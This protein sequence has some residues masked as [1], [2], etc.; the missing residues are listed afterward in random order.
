MADSEADK[1]QTDYFA[2]RDNIQTCGLDVH[3][4]VFFVSGLGVILLVLF[5]LIFHD[6]AADIFGRLRPWLTTQ[7]DWVFM[8]G[9]NI[10]VV[11]CLFLIVSPL[12]KVRIGGADAK[13]HF[14][15]FG[16]FA[17]LFAAGMGIGLV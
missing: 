1:Y 16:W 13:P 7:F 6:L 17:M 11:F 3:N 4:P 10:F 8:V 15:Y 2:G 14:S 5:A 9:M 12:G